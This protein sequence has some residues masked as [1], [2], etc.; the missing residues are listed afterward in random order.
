MILTH[1]PIGK[2]FLPHYALLGYYHATQPNQSFAAIQLSASEFN[3]K[4]STKVQSGHIS[5]KA[6]KQGNFARH[7]LHIYHTIIALG[8]C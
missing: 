1:K 5:N 8:V 2:H 7:Y 4:G 3:V 6:K